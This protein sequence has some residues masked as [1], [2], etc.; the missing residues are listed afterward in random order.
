MLKSTGDKN[1][2]LSNSNYYSAKLS[3]VTALQFLQIG[4]ASLYN[5]FMVSVMLKP[6]LKCH[7]NCLRHSCHTQSISFVKSI[8]L[9]F[10]SH[11]CCIC[12]SVSNLILKLYSEIFFL[13]VCVA[14]NHPIRQERFLLSSAWFCAKVPPTLLCLTKRFKRHKPVRPKSLSTL[15]FLAIPF[16]CQWLWGW[17]SGAKTFFLLWGWA[18]CF[19]LHRKGQQTHYPPRVLEALATTL[20]DTIYGL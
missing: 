16:Y 18:T 5:A 12:F 19:I 20:T 2:S 15:I 9:L 7:I 8:N 4:T 14:E 10:K 13:C 11:W 17:W 1:V 6:Q 3:Y